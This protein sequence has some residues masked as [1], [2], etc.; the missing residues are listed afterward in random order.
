MF[1]RRLLSRFA[2][3]GAF[4]GLVAC[5]TGPEIDDV[6]HT[7]PQGSVSLQRFDDR[8]FHAA[9]PIH[10]PPQT[11]E[12]VLRGLLVKPTQ[13]ILQT[14]IA[15]EADAMRLLTD[16]NVRYLT[17]LLVEG[18][19]RAAPDQQIGFRVTSQHTNSDLP[20]ADKRVALGGIIAGSLY[21]YGRSLHVNVS[22]IQLPTKQGKVSGRTDRG[23]PDSTGLSNHVI[24]FT[25]ASALRPD[26]Y[27]DA[28]STNATI[29]IDYEFLASSRDGTNRPLSTEPTP[30]TVA[31]PTKPS[32]APSTRDGEIEALRQEL[33]EIKK[34][35]AE[36]EEERS[37][38]KP[39]APP[40]P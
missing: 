13:R 1:P 16:E 17:P 35:L 3:F 19:V 29:I 7:S 6:L 4:F 20:K 10:I 18:L 28:R 12:Q 5:A 24:T 30:N 11:I 27:R 26:S 31:E 32:P 2:L 40:A 14:L 15:G 22:L 39:P 23:L 37:G 36:Q 25:P 9:H 33:R 21:V 38:R 34:Q 8:S